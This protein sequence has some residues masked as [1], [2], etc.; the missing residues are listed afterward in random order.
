MLNMK[1]IMDVATKIA[2]SIRA[3]SLRWLFLAHLEK[4][5]CDHSEVLL[6]TDVRWLSRG[7]FLQR[8]RELC[9][10]IKES[11]RVAGHAEYKKLND[12]Q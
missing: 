7:T 12:G 1:E 11:F 4:A 3:R 6:H 8:F 10:E 9:P 5:D 2:C